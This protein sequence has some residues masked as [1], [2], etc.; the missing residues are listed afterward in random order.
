MAPVNTESLPLRWAPGWSEVRQP[1]P[2]EIEL[3]QAI[4]DAAALAVTNVQ[5]RQGGA[6]ALGAEHWKSRRAPPHIGER[7]MRPS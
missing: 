3:L 7:S 1:Q 6:S 2:A 4:A 5:L